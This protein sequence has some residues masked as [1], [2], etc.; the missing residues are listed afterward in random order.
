MEYNPGINEWPVVR[1]RSYV[2]LL[3]YINIVNITGKLCDACKPQYYGLSANNPHGC[4]SC[5]CEPLGSLDQLCDPFTGQCK[6]RTKLQGRQCNECLDG[7]WDFDVGCVACGCHINLAKV[8]Q[9]CDKQTGQCNC[10][11]YVQGVQCNQCID[12]YSLFGDEARKECLGCSC[13][14]AGTQRMESGEIACNKKTGE[15]ICKNNTKGIVC[16]EC[17]DYA[18]NMEESNPEGCTNCGCDPTGHIDG[19]TGDPNGLRCESVDG[20]C[21]TC[22]AQRIGRKC[23]ACDTGQ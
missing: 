15:C 14:P 22:L 1:S 23:D 4:S 21:Q 5:R 12:G 11:R 13:N 6:C 18:Y 7:F 10:K 16:D 20:Y 19:A 3:L 9:H 17:K 2:V 8:D